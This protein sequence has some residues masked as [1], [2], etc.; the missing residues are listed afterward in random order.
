MSKLK[1]LDT[2]TG[3]GEIGD[4]TSFHSQTEPEWFFGRILA[5]NEQM[6]VARRRVEFLA[7][8]ETVHVSFSWCQAA[9][10]QVK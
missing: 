6:T 9:P 8:L 10:R 1:T 4:S 3:F 7:L 2:C 5:P